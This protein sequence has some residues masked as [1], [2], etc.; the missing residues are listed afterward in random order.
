MKWK[1]GAE[2]ECQCSGN[3]VH[4]GLPFGAGF[5]DGASPQNGKA[6]EPLPVQ[7]HEFLGAVNFQSE[8][9]S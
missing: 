8:S 1:G 9:S 6:A 7:P 2:R 5:G 3:G 4:E